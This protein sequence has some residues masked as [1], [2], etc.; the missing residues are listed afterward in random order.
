MATLDREVLAERVVAIERHLKRVNDSLPKTEEDF[1]PGSDA[2]DAVILHL[3]QAIQI[4]IDIALAA[5]VQLRLGTPQSYADAF[6]KLAEGGYLEKALSIRLSHAVGFRN[7]IVHA[8]EQLDLEKIYK[9]AQDG[10]SD[11]KAFLAKVNQWIN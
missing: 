10:P 5:C 7:R 1:L 6:V 2:S 9:I 3:W 4:V 11:L 8:Y